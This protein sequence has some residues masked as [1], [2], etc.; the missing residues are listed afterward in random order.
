MLTILDKYHNQLENIVLHLEDKKSK[1]IIRGHYLKGVIEFLDC[2][3][4]IEQGKL[5]RVSVP[6]LDPM[7]SI[8]YTPKNKSKFELEKLPSENGVFHYY[9]SNYII[10]YFGKNDELQKIYLKLNFC[11][12]IQTRWAM[13]KYIIQ[14]KEMKT[15]IVK[16]IIGALIGL[17]FTLI[18]Q[19][20]LFNNESKENTVV[21]KQETKDIY[22]LEN[23]K[24]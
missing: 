4:F 21:P 16:Y 23:N 5:Y 19:K 20:L 22:E 24:R 1:M 2:E 11:K 15:D 17:I 13:R 18:S 12:S 3:I 8:S 7:D 14:S 9:N 6:E 10:E